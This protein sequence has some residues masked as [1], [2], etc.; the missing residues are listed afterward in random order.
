MADHGLPVLYA[1]FVW[2][3]STGLILYLD[4]LP[5]RTF[6]WSMLGATGLT[7]LALYGLAASSDD[8]SIYGAYCAFTCALMIWGWHEM[9][10]LM[11]FVTGPR[12]TACPDHCRGWR[13]FWHATE[14]ILHHELAIAGTAV[15]MVALTW[16]DANQVGTW[17]FMVLWVMRVSAKLNVFLGVP[18]L[19]E[20]FLPDHLHY[21]KSFLRKKPMNLLFPVSVTSGTIVAT[22]LIQHAGAAQAGSFDATAF[23]FVGALLVLAVIEHWF[24]VLPI[25]DAAL[26]SWGL[27]SRDAASPTRVTTVG[28]AVMPAALARQT[29]TTAARSATSERRALDGVMPTWRRPGPQPILSTSGRQP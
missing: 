5:T 15:V 10:F 16:G 9:S 27:R 4:G 13:H 3:F 25:A 26:W 24:L 2:W 28:S 14:T 21:L 1:L 22:L 23:T 19:A 20:Q 11:G 6:R 29:E 8:V 12:R 18:N 17:T 7:G